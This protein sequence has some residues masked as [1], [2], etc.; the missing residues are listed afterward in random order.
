MAFLPFQ[1]INIQD[2]ILEFLSLI[3]YVFLLIMIFYARRK[4]KI[5]ASK[6]FPLMI[7]AI[8]MGVVG[9]FMDFFTEFY[10][11]DDINNYIIF[12]TVL[13]TLQIASLGTFALSLLLVFMFTR[14]MLGEEEQQDE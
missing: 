11:F 3:A 14:F 1:E 2:A 13:S 5:F 10:W 6:G 9:A 4:N 7:L 8:I 12:K